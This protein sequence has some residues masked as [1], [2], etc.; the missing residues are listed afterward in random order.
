MLFLL[1]NTRVASTGTATAVLMGFF[2]IVAAIAVVLCFFI[3][4]LSFTANVRENSWE[5]GVL[6]AIGLSVNALIRAYIYEAMVL[7]MFCHSCCF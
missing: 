1:V 6:R 7:G 5:F 4:M 3:L 2:N